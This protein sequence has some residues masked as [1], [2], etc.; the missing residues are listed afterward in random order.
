VTK[1][2]QNTTNLIRVII[3]DD[4]FSIRNSLSAFLEDYDF[5]VSTAGSAEEALE[6]M[7]E[8]MRLQQQ[9]HVAIIDL[10][11]PGMSGETLIEHAH[12][13]FPGIRFLVHTG[14]STY[15]SSEEMKKIGIFQEHVFKKP[16]PDLTLLASAVKKLVNCQL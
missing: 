9:Y 10:R 3:V 12:K 6:S 2:S 13:L 14:S 5:R 16:L 4:E 1:P 7:N 8:A 11:L 15:N